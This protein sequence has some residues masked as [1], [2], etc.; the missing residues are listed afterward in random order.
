[1][2]SDGVKQRELVEDLLSTARVYTFICR[3]GRHA[4][5]SRKDS[6]LVVANVVVASL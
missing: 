4:T 1:M 6:I 2:I 5:P 3:C